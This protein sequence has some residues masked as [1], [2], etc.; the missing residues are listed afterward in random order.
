VE[1]KVAVYVCRGCDIGD[2]LDIEAL[3][4]V[5]QE[6][7]AA[8][9]R[10]HEFLCGDEGCEMIR[11]DVQEGANALVVAACTPRFK[12]DTFTFDG[13]RTERVNLREQV[14][15]SHEPNDEDTQMLA[16]DYLR[17]GLARAKKA[18]IA[19]PFEEEID[20]TVL[21]V[22][23]GITG[24]AAAL[25]AAD[26]GRDVVLVEKEPQLGGWSG[27][28]ARTFP[29]RPPYRDPEPIPIKDR[30]AAVDSNDKIKVHT[31][32]TIQRIT[33]QPGQ[34]DVTLAV[35]GS[36]SQFRVGSIVQ[37]T[38]WRPY[39]ASK[40]G[41]LGYGKSPNVVTNVELEEMIAAGAIKRPGDGKP[42]RRIAFIQCAG[43][44]DE[45][46]LPYCSAVCC[47]VTIKQALIARDFDPKAEAY[48]LYKDMRTPSQYEDFYRRAQEDSGIFFTKAD[49]TA[50]VPSGEGLIV[51]AENTLLGEQVKLEADLVVL[52]T[53]MVPNSADGEAIRRYKDAKAIVA[54][55]EAGAQLETAKRTV[56]ELQHVE[57]TEILNLDYR[58]GPDLPV[59]KYD[60]PDS[61]FICFPYETRRTGIYLAGCVRAPNDSQASQEDGA[62]AALKAIQ[63]V[64]LAMDGQA[65]HPRW[66]DTS[67]PDF[68]LQRCT[69]CKRCTEEC[70]F[71]TLNEDVK[72]TPLPNLTRCRRCG[73]CMG[74]CPERIISFK[75]YSVDIISSMIKAVEIPDEFEEKP[76][77]LGLLCENDAYPSLDTAGLKRLKHSAFIRFIPV[78]CLGSVNTVWIA[79][80][81]SRGFDGILLIGCK[82]GDDYQ[83]H[84]IKGS[85][86]MDKRSENVQE[87][88]KQLALEEERVKLVQMPITDY[89]KL[90]QVINEFAEQIEEIGLNP[91][92][93]F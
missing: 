62:G 8:I 39:D 28:F 24:I 30:I 14:V 29:H 38:G 18:E 31:G 78:R 2:S 69:Q 25:T 5:A 93:G 27:K 87:K 11:G 64:G 75:D 22:G 49:V 12:T 86:L 80:A 58:Q 15:W 57:G 46:H 36:S 44:R 33:G 53:G 90:P 3:C 60:F 74:A 79:D 32:A 73:I 42:P 37:A 70:P 81:L 13:C 51:E 19:E 9:C 16:E 84:F 66:G 7:G 82:S 83:C 88:L 77:L 4:G 54:K 50:V 92:K 56:E 45:N 1:K 63:S 55:G 68:F 41:H 59:L 67:F 65:V 91:F 71:G 23:G 10:G 35:N 48:V 61:H 6:N 43:S 52:A 17:M 21:V 76:R 20:E 72:G 40:L 47:R 89:D 26:A 34:F 85:E